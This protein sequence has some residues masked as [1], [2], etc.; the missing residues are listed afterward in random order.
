MN[1]LMAF[2]E[3]MPLRD[4]SNII[5][6]EKMV[7]RFEPDA[8]YIRLGNAIM[9]EL[10]RFHL[11]CGNKVFCNLARMDNKLWEIDTIRRKYKVPSIPNN[12]PIAFSRNF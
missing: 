7:Y 6:A 5:V 8:D 4:G 10:A 11:M 9:R 12:N 2:V 1:N 3:K